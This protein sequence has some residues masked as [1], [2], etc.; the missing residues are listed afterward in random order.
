M[1]RFHIGGAT[2]FEIESDNWMSALGDALA[3]LGIDAG[4]V[5][6]DVLPDGDIEVRGPAGNFV[7]HELVAVSV[8]ARPRLGTLPLD[9]PAAAVLDA[10]DLT[11]AKAWRAHEEESEDQLSEIRERT[12]VLLDKEGNEEVCGAALDLLMEYVP[13]E[14][15]AVLLSHWSGKEMR[16]VAARGPRARGLVGVPVPSGK[17]IAGLTVRTGVGT[18]IREAAADPR[19]YADVDK[20]TGYNTHAILSVPVRGAGGV[21]GCVQLLNPFAGAQFLPWH[22]TAAQLVAGRI[23]ERLA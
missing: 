14:S 8:P 18:I 19:H 20:R 12:R 10:P 17:G 7:I 15:G 9:L 11:A 5:E 22:Q 2:E 21:I 1:A 16:F 6:C 4:A 3:R 13:A 23:A